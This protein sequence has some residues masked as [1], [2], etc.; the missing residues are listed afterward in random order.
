MIIFNY[1]ILACANYSGLAVPLLSFH[2]L[3]GTESKLGEFPHMV[4]I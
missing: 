2:I 1:F 4:Q 3:G